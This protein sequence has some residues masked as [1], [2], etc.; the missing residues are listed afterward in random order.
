MSRKFPGRRNARHDEEDETQPFIGDNDRIDDVPIHHDNHDDSE[1]ALINPSQTSVASS[2]EYQHGLQV[3]QL[4]STSPT[5][6]DIARSIKL[7]PFHRM[8]HSLASTQSESERKLKVR[9]E[10]WFLHDKDLTVFYRPLDRAKAHREVEE[11]RQLLRR[12]GEVLI[13][14]AWRA[15]RSIR[16]GGRVRTLNASI[17]EFVSGEERADADGEYESWRRCQG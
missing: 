3:H 12:T 15:E 11:T 16:Q 2:Q 6:G 17:D 1:N 7:L 14:H 13:F 8:Y 4:R 9:F 10:I 5:D